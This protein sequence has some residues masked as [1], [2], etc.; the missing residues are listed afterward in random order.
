MA[1]IYSFCERKYAVWMDV[2]EASNT[3]S[4]ALI[5]PF[6]WYS[7]CAETRPDCKATYAFLILMAIGSALFHA[8]LRYDAQ[9][10]DESSMLFIMASL[11]ALKRPNKRKIYAL[12]TMISLVYVV[13]R[14]YLFFIGAFGIMVCA[15][16]TQHRRSL[17]LPRA[18]ATALLFLV[19]LTAWVCEHLL[20]ETFEHAYLLH[21][22]W[23]ILGALSICG[24]VELRKG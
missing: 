22:V 10:L 6:A 23:H 2:A 12:T 24:A 15:F 7:F 19:A 20:C 16:A 21:S 9:I 11:L 14:Q 8:T 13:C 4:A 18:R 3:L 1:A 5:I 17:A